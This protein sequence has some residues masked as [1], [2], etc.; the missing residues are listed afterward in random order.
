MQVQQDTEA[1]H[2]QHLQLEDE[3]IDHRN[4]LI[5]ATSTPVASTSKTVLEDLEGL[6]TRVKDLQS[7]GAY[8]AVLEKAEQQRYELVS[9]I[10]ILV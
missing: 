8:F 2:A 10:S 5:S 3:L 6:H 7:A 9:L 1:L 4:E